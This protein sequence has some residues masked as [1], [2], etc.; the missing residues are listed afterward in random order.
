MPV[1]RELGPHVQSLVNRNEAIRIKRLW[2][3]AHMLWCSVVCVHALA[4][5]RESD[6]VTEFQRP[7]C[8]PIPPSYRFWFH[9][10]EPPRNSLGSTGRIADAAMHGFEHFCGHAVNVQS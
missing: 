4:D 7:P 2:L 9:S 8:I 10:T 1:T 5:M 3:M 6:P